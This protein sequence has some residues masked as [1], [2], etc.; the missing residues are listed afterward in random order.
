MSLENAAWEY[1]TKTPTA[2]PAITFLDGATFAGWW[3]MDDQATK[4]IADEFQSM[5]IAWYDGETQLDWEAAA[6]CAVKAVIAKD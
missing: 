2:K 1:A 6:R 5:F 4:I 3:F